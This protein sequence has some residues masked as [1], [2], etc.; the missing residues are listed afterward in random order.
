MDNNKDYDILKISSDEIIH[1][2]QGCSPLQ[3]SKVLLDV[4]LHDQR[5]SL[6]VLQQIELEM[7]NSQSG[8]GDS[9]IQPIILSVC[10]GFVSHPKLNLSKNG[11]TASRLANEIQHFNYNANS[12][13]SDDVRIGKVRLDEHSLKQVDDKGEYN[14]HELE[15]R[16]KL[17]AYRDAQ[18]GENR[19]IFSDL[20]ANEQGQRRTLYKQ[21][22]QHNQAKKERGRSFTQSS[23]DVDHQKPLKKIFDEYGVS[24]GVTLDDLKEAANQDDNLKNIS[25]QLNRSKGDKSWT[26]YSDEVNAKKKAL[27]EK[28]KQAGYLSQTEEAELRSLP[29]EQTLKNALAAEKTATTSIESNL[30]KSV[31]KNFTKDSQLVKELGSEAY[32]QVKDELKQKSIGELIILIIKPIFFEL[33]D[34]LKNG[35]TNGFDTSSKLDAISLRFKRAYNY[36]IEN[37]KHIG[38]DVI[39]DAI[40]NFIKYF[41]NAIVNMFVGILKKG[42]KIISEGFSAIVQSIKI[43]M[44]D[45]NPAQKAE[46]ITKLLA[47]T[48]VTYISFAF[49]ETIAPYVEMIPVIGEYLKDATGIMVSGIGSTIVVWLIDQADIFSNKAELRTKRIKEIFELRIQQIKENTDAFE[50]TAIEKLANDKLQFRQLGEKL[51]GAIEGNR[52]VNKEISGIAEFMHIDLKIKSNDDFLALLGTNKTLEIA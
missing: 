37:I 44:S 49:E 35:V 34:S 13:M 30:N 6:K 12:S 16:S 2:L 26:Q 29:S 51:I 21:G 18:M 33:T 52:D 25:A 24:K 4:E 9:L 20:E 31:V 47:T 8:I 39:K 40:K 1:R 50:H 38:L 19:K 14:R 45:S 42:L 46:A 3:A 7:R 43:L 11:L 15:D 23:I 48:I 41:I 27:K 36:I 17:Y 28:K 22:D 10:D 32:G 5:D